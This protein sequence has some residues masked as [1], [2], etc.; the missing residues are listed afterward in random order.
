MY[1]LD[2]YLL[3][4]CGESGT[5]IIG[6]APL[7]GAIIQ[8]ATLTARR[9]SSVPYHADD[10][11]NDEAYAL[12]VSVHT[13]TSKDSNLQSFWITLPSTADLDTLEAVLQTSVHLTAEDVYEHAEGSDIDTILGKG[14]FNIVRLAKRRKHRKLINPH[15]CQSYRTRQ[16]S[17]PV[18]G[19][20]L[21]T[22]KHSRSHVEDE[23]DRSH[24]PRYLSS[25]EVE[26]FSLPK[27]TEG[28]A[29]MNQQE[30]SCSTDS[31]VHSPCTST[32][33]CVSEESQVF[34]SVSSAGNSQHDPDYSVHSQPSRSY[35]PSFSDTIPSAL[36]A[37][38]YDT[39]KIT[40]PRDSAL[41]DHRSRTVSWENTI[42]SRVAAEL[43]AGK[44]DE[45][46]GD[47]D[48][49][50]SALKVVSKQVFWNRVDSQKE[51]GDSLVREVLAQVLLSSHFLA[52]NSLSR[53]QSNYIASQTPRQLFS[54]PPDSPTLATPLSSI[55][56]VE[57]GELPIVQVLSVF[58]TLDEF[59]LELELMEGRDLYEILA[60][61]TAELSEK[62][63]QQIIS[64]LIDAISLCN[65]LGI[66]HRDVKLSNITVPRRRQRYTAAYNSLKRRNHRLHHMGNASSRLASQCDPSPEDDD[67]DD[68]DDDDYFAIKLADFGMAGFV[69]ADRK[70][71]GRCGTP[72][73]VAPDI[74]WAKPNESYSLNVDMFSVGVV[75]YALLSGVEPF[76]DRE[77]NVLKHNNQ[78]VRYDFD[79]PVWQTVSESAKDFIRKA[80]QLQAET[81]INPEESKRHP[82]LCGFFYNQNKPNVQSALH[83]PHCNGSG[84]ESLD[85]LD[86]K[87]NNSVYYFRQPGAEVHTDR[88][89]QQIISIS[90]STTGESSLSNTTMEAESVGSDIRSSGCSSVHS[91]HHG[92][93]A[94]RNNNNSS[95]T[96]T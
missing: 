20:T 72:G 89:S 25:K 5:S 83:S 19:P 26:L 42:C 29:L 93:L 12:K 66:A 88:V 69:C 71:K 58:E 27:V 84:S 38:E 74:L 79:D 37:L 49:G 46:D 50:F 40:S 87:N 70:L 67:D 21:D 3:E 80:L 30:S 62:Y 94:M 92:S 48:G 81:R 22:A 18:R 16:T 78:F 1:L 8:R 31:T 41:S 53:L 10:A 15:Y 44:C 63:V 68:D 52:P 11:V 82:W 76:Y 91:R 75:A 47:E 23:L 43:N 35:A 85:A 61:S 2:N 60:E 77:V 51:R 33:S 64:Q 32:N 95:C 6:Y 36:S 13:T 28:I 17:T 55:M 45:S 14:R 90:Q 4:C 73:Y 65:R 39:V 9:V 56:S 59:S 7:S 57:S 24:H 34:K 96:I 54:N 86:I